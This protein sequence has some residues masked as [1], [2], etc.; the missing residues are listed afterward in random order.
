MRRIRDSGFRQARPAPVLRL[1]A[2]LP[3][4]AA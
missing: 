4:R 3:A 2:L 1:A